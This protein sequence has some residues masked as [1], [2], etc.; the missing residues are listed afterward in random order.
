M[1]KTKELEKIA[2]EF[3]DIVSHIIEKQADGNVLEYVFYNDDN[4]G[5]AARDDTKKKYVKI[6][7]Y[8]LRRIK[9]NDYLEPLTGLKSD[10]SGIILSM[11]NGR[12]YMNQRDCQSSEILIIDVENFKDLPDLIRLHLR[13]ANLHA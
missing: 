5:I 10:L 3:K 1:E 2:E 8:Q 11:L 4:S 13:L 6:V 7:S 12:N 9:I